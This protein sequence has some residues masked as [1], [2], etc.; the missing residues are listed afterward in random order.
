M[1]MPLQVTHMSKGVPY[2]CAEEKMHGGPPLQ[3]MVAASYQ[4]PSRKHGLG[5]GLLPLRV[6]LCMPP[7]RQMMAAS[8]KD[9][10]AELAN[11]RAEAEAARKERNELRTAL[12]VAKKGKVRAI[13]RRQRHKDGVLSLTN[14]TDGSLTLRGLS[15]AQHPRPRI[16]TMRNGQNTA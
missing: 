9:L 6:V 14:C 12:E 8:Q 4:L 7:H 2:A 5:S 11:A 15:H 10:T 3:R 1:H 13:P 16:M